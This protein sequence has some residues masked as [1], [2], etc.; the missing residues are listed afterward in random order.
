MR[1]TP[2]TQLVLSLEPKCP[3]SP[4]LPSGHRCPGP[5]PPHLKLLNLLLQVSLIL[6]LLVRVGSIV[7]LRD[8]ESRHQ[9][10]WLP[11]CPLIFLCV[12]GIPLPS[13]SQSCFSEVFIIPSP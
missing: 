7:E 6:F 8:G 2:R 1:T 13:L 10:D 9:W 12:L 5:Q 3:L 4:F 11:Q